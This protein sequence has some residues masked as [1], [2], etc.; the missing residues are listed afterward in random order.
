M[1]ANPDVFFT[2]VMTPPVAENSATDPQIRYD[3][4]SGRWILTGVDLAGFNPN[5]ILFAVSDAASAG[6]IS[7]A[8]VW[9]FYFVQIVSRFC[10]YPAL[11]VDSQ[12]LYVG[13]NTFTP[14]S[15][16]F[17][18]TNGYVVR[19]SSVLSGGPLFSTT[20][21]NLATSTSAGPFSPR[22]VDNY[23]PASNEGYFIG[24]DIISSLGTLMLRRVT[25]PGGTPSISGNIS[26]S[27]STTARPIKVDHQG[28]T[29]APTADLDP[30][31]D[32]LMSAHIRNGRLWTAHTV[33]VTARGSPPEP[34][35][36]DAKAVRWYELNGIRSVDNGGVP[37]VVQLRHDLRR[38]RDRGSGAPILDA[39]RDGF[40][41]GHAAFGFSTAGTPFFIRCGDEWAAGR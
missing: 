15:G 26:R 37:V 33:A 10:D 40:G 9:S 25:D 7:G 21:A 36:T 19:K 22:G 32:R 35:P 17:V 12:A 38:G 24:V 11:G 13:C 20:F 5:R 18:G 14:G 30:F 8:T 34:T 23:D 27:V 39:E 31:D 6:T 16:T 4:L 28:D 3:R 29:N 2:S 1:D 41:Q